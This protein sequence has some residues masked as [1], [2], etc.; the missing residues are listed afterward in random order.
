[1]AALLRPEEDREVQRRWQRRVLVAP[2][3]EAGVHRPGAT[4]QHHEIEAGVV[5]PR[6]PSADAPHQ[7]WARSMARPE[8]SS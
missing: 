2:V 8:W 6:Q 4:Q 1:M 5:L 3:H 7:V